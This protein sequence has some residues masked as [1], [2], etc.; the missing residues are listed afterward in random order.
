MQETATTLGAE[1]AHALSEKDF[2]RLSELLHPEIEF[3]AVTPRRFWEADD[4]ATV[5]SDVLRQWFK[6]SDEIESLEQLDGDAFA[7]RERVGYR[8]SV[9]NP[10]GHFLVEQ[11]AY[12]S[13]RDGRIGWM[14]V[15]CAGYRPTAESGDQAT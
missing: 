4:S 3:R 12:I 1:F 11:Q 6:D 13:E 15:V 5:I 10:D 9:R 8:F 7:D 14:R 2:D